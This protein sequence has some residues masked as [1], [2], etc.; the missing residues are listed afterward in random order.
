MYYFTYILHNKNGDD[1]NIDIRKSV[2]DKIKQDDENS[3]I[4][5]INES[6]TSGDE[7]VLPGLGVMLELFWNELNDEVK[8]NI[9]GIIKKSIN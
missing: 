2:I 7:L 8:Y 1:M 4:R 6:I 9:A 5:T 3:I